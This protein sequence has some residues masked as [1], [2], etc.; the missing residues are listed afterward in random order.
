MSLKTYQ[1]RIDNELQQYEK[2]YWSPLSIL[3][4]L[5]EEVGE[6]ARILN[7]QFGDKPKKS[8]E[9]H[10]DLADELADVIYTVICL[11]NSQGIELDKPLLDAIAKL[12][13]RDAGRFKKKESQ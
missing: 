13:T 9:E 8:T 2:P 7:H 4:R 11:A 6:V 12:E 3:A 1:Q 10:E 5:S